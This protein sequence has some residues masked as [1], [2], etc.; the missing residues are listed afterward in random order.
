M[1]TMTRQ[2][3][4]QA[5]DEFILHHYQQMT[6]AEVSDLLP[7]RTRRAVLHRATRLGICWP[8]Q[9]AVRLKESITEQLESRLSEPLGQFLRRRYN[10][11]RAT[12]RE[13]CTELGINTRTLIRR[14]RE[15]GIEPI[16]PI[17]AG[18]RNYQKHLPVYR[19]SFSKRNTDDSRMKSAQT[20]Q[21]DWQRFISAEAYKILQALQAAGLNPVPEFAAFRYNI[22]LAFPQA[23][24]AVEIDGG[25]F[26]Q[27]APHIKK[28]R[29]KARYLISHGW[30]LLRFSTI[31]PIE[32]IVTTVSEAINSAAVTQ[33]R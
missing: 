7:E 19:Q 6:A 13:L 12:Y 28:D 8:N 30:S 11:E 2:F 20:R 10:D 24:L 31:E 14:M 1:V 4:T 5:E 3:W 27:S 23:M 17:T 22:D 9:N 18:K 25:N 33:P 21:R 32:S 16:D 15:Y 26:H 29:R